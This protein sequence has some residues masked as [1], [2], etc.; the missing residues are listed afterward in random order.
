MEGPFKIWRL[1]WPSCFERSCLKHF[2]H[3][4]AIS[5]PKWD[6]RFWGGMTHFNYK[7][8]DLV[9]CLTI[10]CLLIHKRDRHVTIPKARLECR[11]KVCCINSIT[12]LWYFAVNSLWRKQHSALL[13]SRATYPKSNALHWIW[14]LQAPYDRVLGCYRISCAASADERS[15]PGFRVGIGNTVFEMRAHCLYLAGKCVFCSLIIR[16]GTYLISR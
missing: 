6:F 12:S 13:K 10:D 15:M 8:H 14:T 3:F 1:F 7:D 16:N 4:Q 5:A 9:K 11:Q 2:R